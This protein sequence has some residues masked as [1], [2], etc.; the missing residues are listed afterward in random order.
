MTK[1]GYVHLQGVG[2]LPGIPASDLKP[3][4][5]LMWNYGYKSKVVEV[6]RASACFMLITLEW[7]S[8]IT[9]E[10]ERAD[11]RLKKD[12]LVARIQQNQL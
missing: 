10:A 4:D 5:V 7:T 6:L 9:G 11:R 1:P 2:D 12:R 8:K 3:G